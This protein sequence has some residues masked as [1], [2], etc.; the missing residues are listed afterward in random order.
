M[1]TDFTEVTE[2]SGDQVSR[3]QIQRMFTRYYFA[4]KHCEKKDVLELG[5][6]AGQGLGLL[7]KVANKLIGGDYSEP[8]LSMAR[9]HYNDRIPLVRLDA[10]VLPFKS[11]IFDVVVL[12]EAIYYLEEPEFF[13]NEC[14]RILRPRGKIILCNPNKNLHDFNPSPHSY[15]YFSPCDFGNLLSPI[16]FNVKCFGDCKVDYSSYK[17]RFISTV[18]KTM[19]KFDLIPKTMSGKKFLKRLVFGKLVQLP[20]ELTDEMDYCQLPCA[21]DNSSVDIDHKVIFAVASRG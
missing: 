14:S 12:Y 19:V 15:S 20:A 11:Q 1:S 5:C 3:E 16:G 4:K 21:I 10:Q 9:Q 13:A 2:V 8:L 7:E 18:K 17:Q 6:G